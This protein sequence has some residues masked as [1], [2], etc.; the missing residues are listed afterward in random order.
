MQAEQ[1]A[2]QG[3]SGTPMPSMLATFHKGRMGNLPNLSCGVVLP[4]SF[5]ISSAR[6]IEVDGGLSCELQQHDF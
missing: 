4:Q 5:A 6:P 2:I 3:A 1:G